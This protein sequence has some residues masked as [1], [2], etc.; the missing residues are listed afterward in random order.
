MSNNVQPDKTWRIY[1]SSKVQEYM[2]CPRKYFY[3]Y[4]LGWDT[5]EPNVHLVFGEGWHRA[6][7][8]IL[9]EG[10]TNTAIKDAYSIFLKYYRQHY[11]EIQDGGNF[12]KSPDSIVPTLV[13]YI[14]KYKH[15]DNFEVMYTEV[16][17]TV[18]ISD[19]RVVHFRMDSVMRDDTGI[20]SLEHKTGSRLSQA[21]MDQWPLKMQVGTYMH[22]LHSL[23][24]P[25]DVYGIKINGVI[26]KKTKNDYIRVPI[27]KSMDMMNA[28]LW[29]INHQIDLIEWNMD[30]LMK[31]DEADNVLAAFPMNTES[32]TNYGR[33]CKYH[34]FCS[35]W[36]NPLKRADEPPQG[37]VRKF[38]DPSSNEEDANHVMHI[39]KD[40]V[41]GE[42]S[43]TTIKGE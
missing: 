20:F 24:D 16:A 15:T 23:Y 21:W 12:P 41:V 17:G 13:E 14:Q 4:V 28:W 25:K 5:D 7:E 38:W 22:V 40:K 1:D 29:N 43:I 34:D 31:S 37:F 10:Y 18:P 36:A 19:T 26:F 8:H 35:T 3:R 42:A 39:E 27:R 32:C 6:M 9:N 33:A 30:E 11:T 2:T